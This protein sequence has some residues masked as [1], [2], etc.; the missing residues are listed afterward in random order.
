MFVEKQLISLCMDLFMAG[1]HTSSKSLSFAFLYFVRQPDVVM[2]AQQEMDRVIGRERLP[3][4]ADRP[5]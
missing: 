5:K 3:M 2:K 1:S 4:L